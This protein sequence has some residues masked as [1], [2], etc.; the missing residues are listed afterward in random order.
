ML[1]ATLASN[2]HT[3]LPLLVRSGAIGP[4][5]VR[6]FCH[7]QLVTFASKAD[8]R[9]ALRD[10][11]VWPATVGLL[12]VSF[13]AALVPVWLVL[14]IVGLD[15]SGVLLLVIAALVGLGVTWLDAAHRVAG[16]R[17]IAR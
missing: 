1:T 2:G 4:A 14:W 6:R 7:H 11:R 17:F 12:V 16:T 3:H 13:L 15:H 8:Y 10:H 9:H 5:D